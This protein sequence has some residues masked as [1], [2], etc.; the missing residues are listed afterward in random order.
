MRLLDTALAG[1][2]LIAACSDRAEDHANTATESQASSPETHPESTCSF[3]LS[4]N[5]C[6]TGIGRVGATDHSRAEAARRSALN[7]CTFNKTL[8]VDPL[9]SKREQYQYCTVC[10]AGE[11]AEGRGHSIQ[12]A[13]KSARYQLCDQLL[14]GI[15]PSCET[16]QISNALTDFVGKMQPH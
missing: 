4:A 2:A 5:E 11:C 16:R 14:A 1:L 10:R 12:A 7:S 6:L 3:C 9:C 13:A 8:F 15:E